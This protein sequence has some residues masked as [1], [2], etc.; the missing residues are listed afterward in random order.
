MKFKSFLSFAALVGSLSFTTLFAQ[1]MEIDPAASSVAWTATKVVG[2]GHNGT[3]NLS[4]GKLMLDDGM[5]TGGSFAADMTTI[6]VTDLT[7][8]MAE[9][10]S[11]HLFSQDF[12]AVEEHPSAAFTITSVEKSSDGTYMV[13]GDLTI[14]GET[15][16]VT[17]PASVTYEG[18]VV[19]ATGTVTVDR[20]KYGVRY[21]SNSFFDNLGDKAI[22]DEFTLDISLV[23]K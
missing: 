20:T 18:D 5:L 15:A 23:A 4:A 12:F 21:G 19:T 1:T 22:S 14:K 3:V 6:A 16:P 17:F 10:L 9:K 11:G 8:A 7:G 2:G 13:T